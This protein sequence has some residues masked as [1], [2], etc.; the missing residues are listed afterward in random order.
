[1][2]ATCIFTFAVFF[3][4]SVSHAQTPKDDS[5]SK[6]LSI[7]KQSRPLMISD[8][9]VARLAA[10]PLKLEGTSW[11]GA[12]SSIIC[13]FK[14]DGSFEH[15]DIYNNRRKAQGTWKYTGTTSFSATASNPGKVNQEV[16]FEVSLSGSL[17]EKQIRARL[18]YTNTPWG[19]VPPPEDVSKEVTYS[20]K[21][22][23][24]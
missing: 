23:K 1:M 7:L 18:H 2:K 14:A 4:V 10:A 20:L 16:P 11:G 22:S 8:L 5:L 13:T 12:D 19:E 9:V 21:P 6:A 24:R 17:A 3:S 15:I